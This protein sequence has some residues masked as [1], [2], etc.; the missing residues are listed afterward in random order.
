MRVTEKHTQPC[1]QTTSHHSSIACLSFR[2]TRA[3]PLCPRHFLPSLPVVNHSFP[4]GSYRTR[5]RQRPT[6]I[7]DCS[8]HRHVA[9]GPRPRHQSAFHRLRQCTIHAVGSQSEPGPYLV[10]KPY[11]ST[12]PRTT[13]AIMAWIH[14]FGNMEEATASNSTIKARTLRTR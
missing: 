12:H 6:Q 11:E 10:W 13:K 4:C 5:L 9:L 2:R 7:V 14:P 1:R 8:F 3:L